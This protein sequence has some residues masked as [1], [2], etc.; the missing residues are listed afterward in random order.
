[1]YIFLDH[2]LDISN[3]H[4]KGLRT[5]EW[6]ECNVFIWFVCLFFEVC[7]V[8]GIKLGLKPHVMTQI[9]KWTLYFQTMHI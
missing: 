6:K 7:C 5:Q 3:E 9:A 8:Y 4:L 1:M 2:T